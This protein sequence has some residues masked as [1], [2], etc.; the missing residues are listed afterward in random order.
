[1]TWY[2]FGLLNKQLNILASSFICCYSFNLY[3]N[4]VRCILL[5][6]KQLS[7]WQFIQQNLQQN[8][9]VML[10]YVIESKGSS[11]GRRGFLMAVNAVGKM[12]GSLGGGIMEHKFVELAKSKLKLPGIEVSLHQQLHDKKAPKNQSGMICS[13]EQT[14]F[15]CHLNARD[16]STVAL[17]IQ[18]LEKDKNGAL[19]LSLQGIAFSEIVPAENFNLDIQEGGN[20]LYTEKTGYKN[21]LYIAGSGHCALSLSRLM[22]GMDFYIH[23]FDDRAALNTMDQNDFVHQKIVVDDYSTLNELI[24]AG[25]NIFVV[26]MTFGYRSDKVALKALAGK[27]FKYIG[28]MGSKNKVRKL[29]KDLLTEGV[30]ATFFDSIH[31]P[32]GLSIKSETTEEIAV[33]IAAEIIQIKNNN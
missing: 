10:L 29:V 11:P 20:F 7:T 28:V 23:L 17:L 27:Q 15:L 30:P 2:L 25:N 33:S 9:A 13:G 1:M 21:Q 24:P 22:N 6:H 4:H 19:Q 3:L 5:M 18:S 32:I 12:S 31:A 26:I 8:I 14:I 16:T